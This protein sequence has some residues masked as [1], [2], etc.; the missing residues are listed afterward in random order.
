[1]SFDGYMNK[2]LKIFFWSATILC[3]LPCPSTHASYLPDTILIDDSHARYD[4]RDYAT[5]LPDK[6]YSI[7]QIS[8]E[9]FSDKFRAANKFF[10]P[11]KNPSGYW[12][13]FRAS[14][15]N[16][17]LPDRWIIKVVPPQ[18]KKI[19]LYT[20]DP[21][22]KRWTEWHAGY[23]NE[24]RTSW[25][26][27]LFLAHGIRLSVTPVTFYVFV[28]A[29]DSFFNPLLLVTENIFFKERTIENIWTAT[30]FGFAFALISYNLFLFCC[31]W[32][33]SY[34]WYSMQGLSLAIYFLLV[35]GVIFQY[36]LID[37]SLI[38]PFTFAFLAFFHFFSAMFVKTFFATADSPSWFK[39]LLNI[40]PIIPAGFFLAI[41]FLP[42][43]L[44]TTFIS[45]LNVFYP[46]VYLFL[47]SWALQSGYSPARFFLFAWTVLLLVAMLIGLGGLGIVRSLEQML[48]LFQASSLF[49]LLLL[50][51]AL[52]DRIENYRRKKH[53][54]NEINKLKSS[55]ITAVGNDICEPLDKI[56]AE[57]R[58]ML[59][60]KL[61]AQQSKVV[62][63]IQSSAGYLKQIISN[64]NDMDAIE[65]GSVVLLKEQIDFHAFISEIK[66]II[67]PL[68]DAKGIGLVVHKNDLLPDTITSDSVRLRQI[69]LN[70]LGNAVKFTESG[71]VCLEIEMSESGICK[72]S[73]NDTGIGIPPEKLETIFESYA[74]ADS[75]M[76]RKQ[77][78]TGLGLAISKLLIDKMGGSIHV[79]SRLGEGSCFSVIVPLEIDAVHTISGLSD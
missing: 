64:I 23:G 44:T 57:S 73:V 68:A 3:C 6:G 13:R 75:S 67:R 8:S 31:L 49:E 63:I 22:A 16:T 18:I 69:I 17:S 12:L 59:E 34:L 1:M 60:S 35:R 54:A 24:K 78:G 25:Q 62:S 71:K 65:N 4:L 11:G 45:V 52:A 7:S 42:V 5:V 72:F 38:A 10:Y 2:F 53:I 76:S 40:L 41:F 77:N 70:L 20:K 48:I 19:I 30:A 32:D 21:A 15:K 58:Q 74:Q 9:K 36:A 46:A 55:F 27:E 43:V 66:E 51:L 28:Q 50:S 47:G 14:L 37:A 79:H 61:D 33:K 56:N 29:E 26:G 39:T